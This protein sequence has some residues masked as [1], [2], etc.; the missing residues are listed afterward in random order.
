LKF[1]VAEVNIDMMGKEGI[2]T[3]V[4]KLHKSALQEQLVCFL[5][6]EEKGKNK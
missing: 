1:E 5:K 3:Y 4:F 6:E 2:R